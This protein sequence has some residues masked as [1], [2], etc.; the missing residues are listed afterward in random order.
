M[1]DAT[2]KGTGEGDEL[3]MVGM[4]EAKGEIIGTDKGLVVKVKSTG[5][6]VMTILVGAM[7]GVILPG[8]LGFCKGWLDKGS[9]IG[10]GFANAVGFWELKRFTEG[11][12][13]VVVFEDGIN[14]VV[15]DDGEEF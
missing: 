13:E 1:I 7:V 8:T 9:D 3:E 6:E 12:E 2:P 11:L 10:A 14:E 4:L 5:T 15:I